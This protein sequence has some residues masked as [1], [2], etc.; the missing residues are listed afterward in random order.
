LFFKDK[1]NSSTFIANPNSMLSQRAIDRRNKLQISLD[2][3]DVPIDENYISSI[4]NIAGIT[5]L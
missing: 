3:K 2:E 5:V 4:K 1:P